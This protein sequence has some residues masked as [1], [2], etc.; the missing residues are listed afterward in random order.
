MMPRPLRARIPPHAAHIR[1]WYGIR[2]SSSAQGGSVYVTVHGIPHALPNCRPLS[3][4]GD[5]RVPKSL[6]AYITSGGRMF[7]MVSFMSIGVRFRLIAMREGT[8][9]STEVNYRFPI[10]QVSYKFPL[11]EAAMNGTTGINVILPHITSNV[12]VFFT[13]GITCLM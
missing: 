12:H 11:R 2:M 4:C 9:R 1:R 13:E 10:T 8:G 7:P 6:C 5:S 3:L